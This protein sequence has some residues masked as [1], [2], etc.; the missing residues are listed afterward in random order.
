MQ[1]EV[2]LGR[3]AGGQHDHRNRRSPRWA[4]DLML[5]RPMRI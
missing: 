5:D 3:G 2:D 4:L 1:R